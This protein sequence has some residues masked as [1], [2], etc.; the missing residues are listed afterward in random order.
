VKFTLRRRKAPAGGHTIRGAGDEQLPPFADRPGNSERQ[1]PR[2]DTV[3]TQLTFDRDVGMRQMGVAG[4]VSK[5]EICLRR[6]PPV[7]PEDPGGE[8]PPL[9]PLP[10]M[11]PRTAK[12]VGRVVRQHFSP[13]A[14]EMRVARSKHVGRERAVREFENHQK[15]L[16]RECGPVEFTT[17]TALAETGF[18]IWPEGTI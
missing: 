9:R 5:A 2:A 15:L 7:M 4:E 11:R 10:E 14:L 17:S 6:D 12:V 16:A 1:Q 18:N 8:P 3:A 13:H